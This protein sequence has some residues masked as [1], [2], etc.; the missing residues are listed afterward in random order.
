MVVLG[1]NGRMS[2]RR[3]RLGDDEVFRCRYGRGTAMLDDPG[4]RRAFAA[5]GGVLAMGRP[6]ERFDDGFELG[7]EADEF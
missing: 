1:G 6:G 5:I 2:A 3:V 7:P 4:G